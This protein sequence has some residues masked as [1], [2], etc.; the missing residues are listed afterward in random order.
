MWAEQVL[1]EQRD[2]AQAAGYLALI[3]QRGMP[4]TGEA[5]SY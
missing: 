2:F 5:F 1:R 4:Y 3:V